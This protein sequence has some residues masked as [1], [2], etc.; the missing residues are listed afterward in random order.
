MA[1]AEL[2]GTSSAP[3]ALGRP[4]DRMG[5][6]S[7]A[8]GP[9]G[10]L[11]LDA[12][13]GRLM[14]FSVDGSTHSVYR[15]DPSLAAALDVVIASDGVIWVQAVSPCV[16]A[17]RL[18]PGDEVVDVPLAEGL[19]AAKLIPMPRGDMAMG[20]SERV[21]VRSIYVDGA[22]LSEEEQLA[23]RPTGFESHVE[24]LPAPEEALS[25][26]TLSGTRRVD[27]PGRPL[28]VE[29]FGAG[30][31]NSF[32]VAALV[33]SREEGLLNVLTILDEAGAVARQVSAPASEQFRTTQR[34]FAAS[35]DGRVFQL[36]TGDEGY[37]I[38]EWNTG[39]P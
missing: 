27:L 24:I 6:R 26:V 18:G 29:L 38:V 11:L 3:E 25:F 10:V 7:L 36:R 33:F 22:P 21:E 19:M 20:P 31:R 13:R 15:Q 39:C 23:S 4:G 28:A 17:R 30:C 2:V 9:M 37:E 35:G 32:Q 14:S 34:S 1:L 16:C 12:V 8:A 5:P